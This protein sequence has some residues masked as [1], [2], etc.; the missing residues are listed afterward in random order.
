MLDLLTRACVCVCVCVHAWLCGG[1]V[2]R[3]YHH[4]YEHGLL[5]RDAMDELLMAEA[6]QT[7]HVVRSSDSPCS[8]CCIVAGL[9][10][11]VTWC[12]RRSP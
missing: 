10:L 11:P 12:H 7:H 1:Q 6:T 5:G 2:E 8:T 4:L 9:I 3:R